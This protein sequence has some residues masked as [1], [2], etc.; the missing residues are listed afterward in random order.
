MRLYLRKPLAA[1]RSQVKKLLY[2]ACQMFRNWLKLLYDEVTKINNNRNKNHPQKLPE[3][4]LPGGPCIDIQNKWF[5]RITPL[6]SHD[7]LSPSTMAK[8]VMWFVPAVIF[9]SFSVIKKC[10]ESYGTPKHERRMVRNL[11]YDTVFRQFRFQGSVFLVVYLET[12]LPTPTFSVF[13]CL[14]WSSR[15]W[16]RRLCHYHNSFLLPMANSQVCCLIS[17]LE[18]QEFVPRVTY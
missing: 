13:L 3:T 7:H 9:S 16:V 1:L 17:V 5:I 18:C 6:K 14:W 8:V 15:N 2:M 12:R 11:G 10:S 4:G